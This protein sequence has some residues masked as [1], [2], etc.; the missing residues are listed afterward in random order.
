MSNINQLSLNVGL[1]GGGT[2]TA[3]PTGPD[4]TTSFFKIG[5]TP[6]AGQFPGDGILPVLALAT[7]T[8]NGQGNQWVCQT[9]TLAATTYD[10]LNLRSSSS[11]L[12]NS[13]GQNVQFTNV[14]GIILVVNSHDG[15]K[16]LQ[17]GPQGQSNAWPGWW[18]AVTA[19]FYDTEYWAVAK[20][21]DMNTGLGP[22]VTPTTNI[23]PIY[24]PTANPITYSIFIVGNE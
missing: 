16:K 21:Q 22:A 15:T 24:N 12:L 11:G 10:L 18:E 17:I 4:S 23:L 2:L 8:G 1:S 13:L 3:A 7:G 19:N 14:K 20:F 9:R 6:S 5:T